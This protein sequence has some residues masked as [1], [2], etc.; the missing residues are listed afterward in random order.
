VILIVQDGNQRT[1]DKETEAERQ[2][3]REYVQGGEGG[4]AGCRREVLDGYLDGREGRAGR[5]EEDNEEMCDVCRGIDGQLEEVV[6][7]ET[8]AESETN[9]NN[10]EEMDVV[11]A[12]RE[13]MQRVFRQQEQARRG[14]W[15]TLTKHRQ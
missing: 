3:V 11:E 8:E 9:N 7:E 14:P 12:E 6:K 4:V 13:E 1:N 5:R 2:L 10:R 15:Q